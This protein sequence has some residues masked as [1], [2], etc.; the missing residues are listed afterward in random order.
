M[1]RAEVESAIPGELKRVLLLLC[2][3]VSARSWVDLCLTRWVSS[4]CCLQLPTDAM[5]DILEDYCITP[6]KKSGATK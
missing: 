2:P 3:S 4:W 6:I 5:C 1:V